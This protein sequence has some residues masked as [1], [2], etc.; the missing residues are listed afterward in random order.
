VRI[1]KPIASALLAAVALSL[2]GGRAAAG[3][4]R[5]AGPTTISH[6]ERASALAGPIASAQTSLAKLQKDK[7]RRKYRDGW[8]AIAKDLAGAIRKAPFDPRADEARLLVAHVREELWAVSR[9]AVDG[10]AAV[11][12]DMALDDVHPGSEAARAGLLSAVRLA[13]RARLSKELAKAA[14]KL[15]RYPRSSEINEALALAPANA[16]ERESHARALA[17]GKGLGARAATASDRA[18]VQPVERDD[19]DSEVAP[20]AKPA[21]APAKPASAHP[22]LREERLGRGAPPSPDREPDT[23]VP[24]GAANVIDQIVQAARGQ[25]AS[26]LLGEK[27]LPANPPEVA[28]ARDVSARDPIAIEAPKFG[29]DK[30]DDGE[31]EGSPEPEAADEAEVAPSPH[32]TM[33]SAPRSFDSQSDAL[34]EQRARDLRKAA[35]SSSSGSMAAQLGLKVRRV[36]VDAGHGGRDTGAIGPH[37]LREKDVTL[38]IAERLME[39]LR[40]AGLEVVMTRDDDTYV[41]LNERTRIA[42]EANAD[43]FLS[44]HCNAAKRRKLTGVETWTLNVSADRYAQRLASFENAEAEATVSNLRL[45]LADLATKANASD[46]R[47]LAETVQSSMVKTLRTK[48]GKVKDNGV[49]QALFY[50]LLGTHMPSILVETAFLSNP[51]EEKRLRSAKYQDGAAEAIASG[52]KKFIDARRELAR[53]P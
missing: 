16:V 15:A 28:S 45:I 5:R 13:H 40:A 10:R 46:A 22:S 7:R 23:D 36:V 14:K 31:A 25:G 27:A 44:V 2:S 53:A 3:Q 18:A 19:D 43:L 20:I 42:N 9:A 17:S 32:H 52:V 49:K 11:G 48:V 41:S 24:A 51:D 21:V 12:A 6:R 50:V 35:L 38:A 1:L 8:D 26:D 39:K 34:S 30:S 29:A 47:E 33:A 37:G 4:G